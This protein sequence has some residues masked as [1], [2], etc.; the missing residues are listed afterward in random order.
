[1]RGSIAEVMEGRVTDLS[2]RLTQDTG[3]VLAVDRLRSFG[4]A[5]LFGVDDGGGW[6]ADAVYAQRD[7]RGH[8]RELGSGGTHGEGW[9]TPWKPPEGG[10]DG[11]AL[12]F[13][14]TAGLTVFEGSDPQVEA[15]LRAV[16]GFAAPEATE[17]Q[18]TDSAGDR[19]VEVL[20]PMGAFVVLHVGHG[21]FTI[22]ALNPSGPS[23][24][25]WDF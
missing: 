19:L 9:P 5:F 6:A 11:K 8:W 18:L 7:E 17:L 20:S 23:S 15:D 4:A 24:Q 2:D 16:V 12:R 21:P 10:W 1:M 22:T 13:I 25:S 3:E 14:V